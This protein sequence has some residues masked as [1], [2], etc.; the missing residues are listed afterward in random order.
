MDSPNLGPMPYA[1]VAG[2]AFSLT[3][4][5]LCGHLLG[6]NSEKKVVV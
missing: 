2:K 3:C 1:M 5:T 6:E 4:C